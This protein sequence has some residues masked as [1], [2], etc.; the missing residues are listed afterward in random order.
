MTT[1]DLM[2]AKQIYLN[3]YYE[4][5][6]KQLATLQSPELHSLAEIKK[7]FA[8]WENRK[9]HPSRLQVILSNTWRQGV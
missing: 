3:M 6:L 9:E 5:W 1:D 4:Y 7:A 2:K 8:Q